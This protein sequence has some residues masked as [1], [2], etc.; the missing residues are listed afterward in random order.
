MKCLEFLPRVIALGHLWRGEV[1]VEGTSSR[2][3]KFRK[4]LS[5]GPAG[6][7]RPVPKVE[8]LVLS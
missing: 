6:V 4:V 5:K 2:N 7:I 3:L 1:I 8:G